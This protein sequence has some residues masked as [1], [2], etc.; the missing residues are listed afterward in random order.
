M[1]GFRMLAPF[2]SSPFRPRLLAVFLLLAATAS[3][4][5]DADIPK[6]LLTGGDLTNWRGDT[7]AWEIVDSA[8]V[9]S[10][11][12][13]RLEPIPGSDG[14][15][16]G[17]EG[18]TV[19][20]VSKPE[21]GDIRAHVEFMV[22]EGSNS[23]VY[24][25][26]RYEVQVFDSFGKVWP[27]Y[28]DCGGIY[29]RWDDGREPKGFEGRAPRVN[30]AREAGEWQ[31]FDVVFRA[32][33]FDGQGNKI[34][35][36]RF[37]KV[38]HNGVLIHEN[39]ELTGP[40]RASLYQ[41]EQP[42]GPLMLQGDHGPVAY[43]NIWVTQ[44]GAAMKALDNPF[45]AMDTGTKDDAH[46]SIEAQA[47]MLAELGYAGYGST[48]FATL[49]DVLAA[50]DA[51]GLNLFTIYTGAKI[52]PDGYSYDPALKEGVKLLKGRNTMLW[53]YIQSDA[54]KP[55][56]SAGDEQAVA[57][58]KEITDIAAESGVSVALYPHTW[59]WVERVEDAVRMV[60]K[61]NR[62]NL[63]ATFNLCHW[64]K[65][66]GGKDRDAVLKA[67]VPH[68]FIVTINGA[69]PGDDWNALI[70]T[71]DRGSYDV[72]GFM[73]ALKDLG[74]VGPVGLQGYGI[75]GDAHDNLKRSMDAWSKMTGRQAR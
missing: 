54:F 71:L 72:T 55:S 56:D 22:P 29:Q 6:Q 58:L 26:G 70:Q 37:V 17:P 10:A 14:L 42:R 63:G 65:V 35:N 2:G 8:M 9:D 68:L 25:Q 47:D 39:V 44:E 43:R 62:P 45:F 1:K 32:P 41:D 4:L 46:Q 27:E 49:P 60:E 69:D 13:K 24:F 19:D 34:A 3:A 66:T 59:F 48:D 38:I 67:V 31:A 7:G 23:G 57:L 5:D 33:R 30:A 64:L 40:T 36:A 28:V 11:D 52:G 75:G 18:K 50:L 51:K 74:Y 61:V 73:G 12:P 16:N 21:F 15:Y 20:L 53:V